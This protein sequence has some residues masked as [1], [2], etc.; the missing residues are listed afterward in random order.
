MSDWREHGIAGYA[1]DGR[2]AGQERRMRDKLSMNKKLD[3]ETELAKYQ[4]ATRAWMARAQ[5]AEAALEVLRETV[6]KYRDAGSSLRGK[7][8]G[9]ALHSLH[10]TNVISAPGRKAAE[11]K[12]NQ[13]LLEGIDPH[14]ELSEAERARRLEYA[15]KSHFASL[16]LQRHNANRQAK[17][18]AES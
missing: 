13:R 6:R 7:P 16:V 15:R 3:A 2:A 1:A 12:L 5:K 17:A 14:G 11:S 9:F 18:G 4:N 10:D 8:G